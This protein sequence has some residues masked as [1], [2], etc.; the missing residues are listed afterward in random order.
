MKSFNVPRGQTQPQKTLPNTR[1]KAT[2]MRDKK[3]AVGTTYEERKVVMRIKG[4]KWRKMRTG[5]AISSVPL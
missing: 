4:S 5:Y 3:S 2:V 1:V